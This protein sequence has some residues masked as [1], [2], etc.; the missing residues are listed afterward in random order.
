VKL[1]HICFGGGEFIT[2][3][4]IGLVGVMLG[5]LISEYFRRRSR[6]EDYAKEVFTKRLKIYEELYLKMSNA[7]RVASD[8][9]QS[10]SLSEDERKEIWSDVVFD[11]ATFN[12]TNELF[13][14]E[15]IAFHCLVTLIGVDDIYYLKDADEKEVEKE[16]FY[17]NSV[18]T[19]GMI[20]DETRLE[21]IDQYFGALTKARHR[22]EYIELYEAARKK[23]NRQS[24]VR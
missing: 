7:R 11:V 6:I 13:I 19:I 1:W 5:L 18:K 10:S 22:S 4:I 15:D 8:V 16:K 9:I 20:R 3:A 2:G 12:D 14:N 17:R 21:Q 24:R 23:Y